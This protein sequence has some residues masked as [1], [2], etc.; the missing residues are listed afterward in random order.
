[1]ICRGGPI[2]YFKDSEGLGT[3]EVDEEEHPRNV[4]A[5]LPGHRDQRWV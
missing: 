4:Q 2:R 3:P 5:E 1:M